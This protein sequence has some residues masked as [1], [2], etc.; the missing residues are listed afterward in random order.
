MRGS[1]KKVT[2]ADQLKAAE[3]N[4]MKKD[5]YADKYKTSMSM[6][7]P[8]F[9]DDKDLFDKK[10]KITSRYSLRRLL[11]QSKWV[12]SG[13]PSNY[14]I[15]WLWKVV[16]KDPNKYAYKQNFMFSG[17]LFTFEYLNPKYRNTKQL[18]WFD[19]YP[20]VLS[21]G[22]VVTKNGIRNIGFNLHLLPPRVR[23]VVLCEVFELYKNLYRYNIYFNKTR[24]VNIDYKI[25]MKSCLK[26]GAGFSVRMYIPARQRVKILFPYN[27]WYRAC[28]LPS[29]S[30]DG[31]K[32]QKLIQEWSKYVKKLGYRTSKNI[33]WKSTI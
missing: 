33:D 24:A 4:S 15:Q 1:K 11:K 18:P 27:E 13:R 23:I 19:R 17:G 16:F 22:P 21:L 29:R 14:A 10:G 28:F 5:I 30:Y 3:S 25:I 20:L 6:M 31:I 7:E 12:K 26:Y 9:E 2:L 32:A 8:E